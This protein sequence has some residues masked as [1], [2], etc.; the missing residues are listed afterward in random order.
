MNG[1]GRQW[2]YRWT[3][4]GRERYPA[5]SFFFHCMEIYIQQIENLRDINHYF[6]LLIQLEQKQSSD[7]K[8]PNP[9][10]S[11]QT[12]DFFQN[13]FHSKYILEI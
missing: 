5:S 4:T 2:T 12:I 3:H 6:F 7:E 11:K 10:K 9:P 13:R 8:N 1:F